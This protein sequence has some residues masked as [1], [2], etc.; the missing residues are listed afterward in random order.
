MTTERDVI[1][2]GVEAMIR[3]DYTMESGLVYAHMTADQIITAWLRQEGRYS[4][5]TWTR[6]VNLTI[7]SYRETR[8]G[9]VHVLH[10]GTT[11]RRAKKLRPEQRAEVIALVQSG[12]THRRVAAQFRLA[13]S[14]VSKIVAQ[15]RDRAA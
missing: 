11:R 8:G 7:D 13:V 15:H 4:L 10:N 5:R 3:Y 2:L 14:S 9:A 1:R 12:M 6:L